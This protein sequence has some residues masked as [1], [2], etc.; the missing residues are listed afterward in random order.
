MIV[1]TSY[2]IHYTKLYEITGAK[3]S[4]CY[5]DNRA[6][7]HLHGG[8]TPWISDGSPHQWITPADNTISFRNNFV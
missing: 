6:S 4:G 8:I 3:P 1:I 5:T 2:S 7:I